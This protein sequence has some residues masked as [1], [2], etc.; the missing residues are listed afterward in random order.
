ME[1]VFDGLGETLWVVDELEVI[2]GL[3]SVLLELTDQTPHD[4][5]DHLIRSLQ[6]AVGGGHQGEGVRPGMSSLL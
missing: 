5:L 6:L 2:H 1:H 4:L 3:S